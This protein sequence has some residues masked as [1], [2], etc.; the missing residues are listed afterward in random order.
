MKKIL[1]LATLGL[2]SLAASPAF[3]QI[4]VDGKLD[5]AE[6]GT[7]EGKYQLVGEYTGTH[8]SADKGLK[9]LYVGSSATKLYIMTVAS[10][11]TTGYDALVLYLNV[12]DKAGVAA[13]TKL[14]GGA[15]GDSPLKHKPTFDMEVDYG[16]RATTAPLADN[17]VYYSYTDY[18]NGNT[19]AV[20]DAYQGNSTKAGVAITA[21]AAAPSPLA[22]ARLAYT[23][24]ATLSTNL[25]N[26]GVEIE[27]DMAALGLN[28]GERVDMVVGYTNGD[29]VYTSDLLPQIAG[30]TTAIGAD[31]DFTAIDGKQSFAYVIGTGILASRSAAS[32][33][34]GFQVYPNPARQTK[35]N[36]VVAGQKDV[37]LEVFNLMGQRVRTL[38][39]GKQS[40]SQSV[41]LSELKAGTYLVKLRVGDQMTSQKV[42]IL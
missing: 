30:Q 25:T 40:G 10:P 5:A 15:A 2:L 7:G 22:G 34:L 6:V 19:A 8:S 18:T 24:S 41:P 12:P 3:A 31:P 27:L 21:N 29:G 14:I 20:P 42:V 39:A 28:A 38:V 4:T 23:S 13:G 16:I 17:N 26:T 9:A 32:K 35:V 1:T 36:Y 37:A 33:T 11:E